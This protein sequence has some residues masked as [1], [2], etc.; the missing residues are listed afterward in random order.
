[1]TASA[2]LIISREQWGARYGDGKTGATYPADEVWLHHSATVAPDVTPPYDDDY[3]AVRKLEAVGAARFGIHYGLSYTFVVS[4]AGLVFAGHDVRKL[5]AH[6]AGHN[7]IGRAICLLGNYEDRDMTPAQCDAVVWLLREGKTRGWWTRAA[8]SGGHRDTKATAC[9]GARA[10]AEIP[11]LNRRA[12]ANTPRS[13]SAPV[14]LRP[15]LPTLKEGMRDHDGVRRLQEFLCRVFPT[16]AGHL[17]V[18]GDFGPNTAE[19]VAEFQRRTGLVAD[20]VVGSRTNAELARY[21]YRV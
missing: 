19:A 5:G 12:A 6:T 4:P 1:M 11:E 10:Y 7:T 13:T 16:Y 8:L 20:G 17:A 14:T 9:P 2:G 21:G 15:A 18:D 3:T